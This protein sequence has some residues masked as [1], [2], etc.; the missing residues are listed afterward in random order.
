LFIIHSLVHA[1][2]RQNEKEKW[3]AINSFYVF[4]NGNSV[5]YD[6]N[7][8]SYTHNEPKIYIKTNRGHEG[9]EHI[10]IFISLKRI[11]FLLKKE[12]LCVCMMKR[13]LFGEH[14][15]KF[16]YFLLLLLTSCTRYEENIFFLYCYEHKVVLSL[17]LTSIFFYNI[18]HWLLLLFLL[19][20]ITSL[21]ANII[22]QQKNVSDFVDGERKITNS[23]LLQAN[24]MLFFHS[25]NGWKIFFS[26][27]VAHASQYFP[28][29][30]HEITF[31]SCRILYISM[32]L[33]CIK[34]KIN[35]RSN[36]DKLSITQ[37]W[38]QRKK[39]HWTLFIII[40]TQHDGFCF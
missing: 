33:R 31:W 27:R 4:W 3:N 12:Y 11:F 22:S 1:N 21:A 26:S 35:K 8:S 18:M 34:V 38:W 32:L 6:Q 10:F 25:R 40:N 39:E 17:S 23:F 13:K 28:C 14:D 7:F 20:L 5:G 37:Q 30:I 15:E 24:F 16:D 36:D 9:K 2:W 29:I 19:F